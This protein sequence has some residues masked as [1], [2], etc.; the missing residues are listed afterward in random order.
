MKRKIKKIIFLLIL[1]LICIVIFN[2]IDKSSIVKK[3]IN[4]V[5]GTFYTEDEQNLQT[6][7]IEKQIKAV[8]E[9]VYRY[10]SQGTQLQYDTYRKNLSS[11]PEDATSQ[12][13]VYTVCSGLV[14]QSYYQAL[15]IMLPDDT[16]KLLDYAKDN[17]ANKDVVLAYYGSKDEMYTE[18]VIGI[19]NSPN[20]AELAKEWSKF[21]KPGDIFVITGHAMLIESVDVANSKV[22]IIETGY[23]EIGSDEVDRYDCEKHCDVYEAN[24]TIR[25][26]NLKEKL[27]VYY[28]KYNKRR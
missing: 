24:G 20:Y 1:V 25:R 21:L 4:A 9:T 13:P 19:K 18:N 28:N 10:E 7:E 2:A 5:I 6:Q 15:G 27:T 22:T 17:K 3:Q 11:S 12:H 16:T 26:M 14:Y 23:G 8:M